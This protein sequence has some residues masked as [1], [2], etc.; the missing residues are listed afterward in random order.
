[1]DM[2]VTCPNG[3]RLRVDRRYAGRKGMCPRCQSRFDLPAQP[4]TSESSIVAI[5]GDCDAQRTS[6]APAPAA[7]PVPR[8][9]C[10]K[11]KAEM[12]AKYHICPY[13]RTYLPLMNE[14]RAS[15]PSCGSVSFP[16]DKTC[17]VCSASLVNPG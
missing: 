12:S 17:R 6:I 3:H 7:P 15:C 14:V 11:C 5:L 9:R 4:K 1:M 2:K 13:C 16:G 10:P 8:R